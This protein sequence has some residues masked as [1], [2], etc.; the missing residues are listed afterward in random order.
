MKRYANIVG[1]PI[2]NT[3]GNSI[4]ST[5][6]LVEV[7]SEIIMCLLDPDTKRLTKIASNKIQENKIKIWKVATNLALYKPD[8]DNS[9]YWSPLLYRPNSIAS[10]A[11]KVPV[12]MTNQQAQ[13]NQI[14]DAAKKKAQLVVN[15]DI[16]SEQEHQEKEKCT[17]L[18]TSWKKILRSHTIMVVSLVEEE[19]KVKDTLKK[20]TRDEKN[21]LKNHYDQIVGFAWILLITGDA[22]EALREWAGIDSPK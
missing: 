7:E 2:N 6:I 4:C 16:E 18:Q 10:S 19:M 9:L 5:N 20:I 3:I 22:N 14:Y 12:K 13:L 1:K 15:I 21:P 8:S 11:F 17:I